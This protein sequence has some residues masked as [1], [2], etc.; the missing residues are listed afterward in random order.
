MPSEIVSFILMSYTHQSIPYAFI[1]TYN[2]FSHP[3]DNIRPFAVRNCFLIT[4]LYF[5]DTIPSFWLDVNHCTERRRLT[6]QQ[7][8]TVTGS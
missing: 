6:S 5:L 4:A 7:P 3:N 2:K 1:L 8:P